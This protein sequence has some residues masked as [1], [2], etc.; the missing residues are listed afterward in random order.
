MN[1]LFQEL[2]SGGVEEGGDVY[3]YILEGGAAPKKSMKQLQAC[4]ELLQAVMLK[5]GKLMKDNLEYIFQTILW[6]GFIVADSST[7]ALGYKAVRNSVYSQMSTFFAKFTQFTVPERGMDA[8]Y[9]IFVWKP[10]ENFDKDYIH[11]PTGLLQLILCWSKE[12]IYR[13]HLVPTHPTS[14]VRIL[15]NV[16]KVLLKSTTANKVVDTVLEV[17]SNLVTAEEDG[18]ETE[19]E[20]VGVGIALKELDTLLV[21]FDDW[22]KAGN[23]DAK[24]LKKVELLFF[25]DITDTT[26]FLHY[27]T[28]IRLIVFPFYHSL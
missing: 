4:I 27:K 26:P 6:I 28:Q 17:F 7:K 22:I 18:M 8:V 3:Q 14:N 5:L 19:E 9:R 20:S 12:P 10:L 2:Y 23:Q 13:K 16:V 1:L 25:F 15:E 11:S 21:H 24:K